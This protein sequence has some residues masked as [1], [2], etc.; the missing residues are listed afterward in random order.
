MKSDVV[1]SKPALAVQQ[2]INLKENDIVN[3]G[4]AE[5][6]GRSG[7]VSGWRPIAAEMFAAIYGTVM[8]LEA[9]E[10]ERTG[11]ITFAATVL[12]FLQLASTKLKL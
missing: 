8:L 7:A 6:A 2:E 1:G 11:N 9:H 10:R 12:D 3:M 5:L 4:M